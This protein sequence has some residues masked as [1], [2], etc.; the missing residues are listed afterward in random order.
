MTGTCLGGKQTLT[1]TQESGFRLQSRQTLN[2]T[3]ETALGHLRCCKASFHLGGI[4]FPVTAVVVQ[5]EALLQ[6]MA[7]YPPST[8]RWTCL[9]H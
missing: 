8:V 4:Y 3:E 1:A 2:N 6:Q 7:S 5:R 9:L